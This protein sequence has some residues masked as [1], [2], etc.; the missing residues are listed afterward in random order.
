MFC[1]DNVEI[2]IHT[3]N[4][5]VSEYFDLFFLIGLACKR[6]GYEAG[7]YLKSIQVRTP[8][9]HTSKFSLKN[10]FILST[11]YLPSFPD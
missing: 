6:P 9:S 8:F 10:V 11:T 2:Q 1:V 3:E 4:R 5:N 7:I